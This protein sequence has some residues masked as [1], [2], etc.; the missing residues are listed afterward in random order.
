MKKVLGIVL[1]IAMMLSMCVGLTITSSAA[2]EVPTRPATAVNLATADT[3]TVA[4]TGNVGTAV[5]DKATGSIEIPLSSGTPSISFTVPD[6]ALTDNYAVAFNIKM[7]GGWETNG[8][9]LTLGEGGEIKVEK[10]K[11]IA[12]NVHGRITLDGVTALEGDD[13]RGNLVTNSV[14]VFAHVYANEN[15]ATKRDVDFYY[16]GKYIGSMTDVTPSNTITIKTLV[17]GWGDHLNI[18]NMD[19]FNGPEQP[20][21]D[22]GSTTPSTPQDP[23]NPARDPAAANVNLATS[24]DT[25][26]T[27]LNTTKATFDTATSSISIPCEGGTPGVSFAIPDGLLADRY[28]VSFNAKMSG[29]WESSGLNLTW[30]DSAVISVEKAKDVGGRIS[31][32]GTEIITD[33]DIRKKLVDGKLGAVAVLAYVYPNAD[34]A[35]KNDVDF[36]YDGELI[37]TMKAVALSDTITIKTI[38]QGWGDSFKLT[39]V[40]ICNDTS[41]VPGGAAD[42]AGDGSG[43]TSSAGAI[44]DGVDTSK[45]GTGTNIE[46]LAPADPADPNNNLINFDTA[47]K[48]EKVTIEE[49]VVTVPT[50]N[51][52]ISF[53]LS[54]IKATDDYIIK[55]KTTSLNWWPH[56]SLAVTF[57]K[58]GAT[59]QEFIFKGNAKPNGA[60]KDVCTYYQGTSEAKATTAVNMKVPSST[61][62]ETAYTIYVTTSPE[63]G[64]RRIFFFANGKPFMAVAE[65]G[66][67]STLA[68]QDQDCITPCLTFRSNANNANYIISEIQAYVAEAPSYK[69]PIADKEYKTPPIALPTAKNYAQIDKATFTGSGEVT[70]D[71]TIIAPGGNAPASSVTIPLTGL[72]SK[73]D[74]VISFMTTTCSYDNWQTLNVTFG[75]DKDGNLQQLRMRGSSAYHS[76][77]Q[78]GSETR[79]KATA[80][81][82]SLTKIDIMVSTSVETGKRR[83]MVFQDGQA[84]CLYNDKE[85][86]FETKNGSFMDPTLVFSGGTNATFKITNL[87]V[88]KMSQ[89]KGWTGGSNTGNASKAAGALAVTAAIAL[90]VIFW[91]RKKRED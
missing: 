2:S 14:D 6:G 36:Y 11:D 59:L 43:A 79:L 8:F 55:F 49:G 68:I 40:K 71:G 10:A 5:F 30:S 53:D 58:S 70:S 25:S 83:I 48:T 42:G 89:T 69:E 56:E 50:A 75:K 52:S 62:V 28:V 7:G 37:G 74:Y 61:L 82:N 86:A 29:G 57:G 27:V 88:Y 47:E 65:D 73:D 16:A 54:G 91:T 77:M 44:V 72:T 38:A 17:Q 23:S 18:K 1:T 21:N 32:N 84:A 81:K 20:V 4:T 15:D 33:N 63:T 34:D 66:T 67:E 87:K 35:S 26:I 13:I 90:P 78:S 12:P 9:T 3:T 24:A 31:F 19:I 46:I 76:L 45:K 60:T 22:G 80:D 51:S 64:K 39:D 85:T 41:L